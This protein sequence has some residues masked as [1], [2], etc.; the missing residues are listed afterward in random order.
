MHTV[1][2][3]N[4]AYLLCILWFAL[5]LILFFE[6]KTKPSSGLTLIYATQLSILHLPGG[7]ILL[8]PWYEYYPRVW[9]FL[10]FQITNF[11]LIAFVAGVLFARFALPS[12]TIAP[13]QPNPLATRR[14]GAW[15]IAIGFGFTILIS[16]ANFLFQIPSV[17]A[18]LSA[19]WLLGAPGLCIYMHSFILNG[20]KIPPHVY[21]IALGFPAL[22]M[23]LLGFLGFGITYVIFLICFSISRRYFPKL[24]FT[25]APAIVYIGVSF[26][27]NYFAQRSD[28]RDAVWGE[29][30]L[31]VRADAVSVIF[32]DFQWFDPGDFFHL[33][34]LDDR[35]NQNW[36]VGAAA[37]SLEFGHTEFLGGKSL[38]LALVAWVPR[39]IWIN[40]P[41]VAGSGGLATQLTGLTF[42][43]STSVGVGHILELYGNFGDTSL[44]IGMFIIGF[45]L[46]AID[47]RATEYLEKNNIVM[48]VR[49]VI[50]GIALTNAG[51][52]FSE[53]VSGVA[54]LIIL[55]YLLQFSITRLS[56]GFD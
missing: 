29:K 47:L 50:P 37:E 2:D 1:I 51:G 3:H 48:W 23:I 38:S 12:A 10:G 28:I 21:L 36:L 9:T 27:I 26:F 34:A 49:W 5:L 40:K 55:G 8:V 33:R 32:T 7:M 16:Q 19:T 43:E 18:L 56:R 54:T 44:Y 35:L 46:R 52:Q 39:A 53:T 14:L 22:S 17:S 11:G 24:A 41:S 30:A 45:I 31:S 4:A 13:K 20:D 6:A 15:L 25:L 42:A